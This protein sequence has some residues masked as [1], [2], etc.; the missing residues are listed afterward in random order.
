MQPDDIATEIDAARDLLAATAAAHLG[1]V[2]ADGTPR[3]VPV[4]FWWTGEEFVVSTAPE[5]PKVAALR[6]R[7]DVALSV[8]AG[9][10]PE[11]A[12]A[13]SVR[14]RVEITV[15]EGI[16]PEYLMAARRTMGE[17]SA[18]DFEAHVRTV[19][20]QQAR[21]A[22]RP[23]WARFYDYSDPD[24]MPAFLQRLVATSGS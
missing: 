14:G 9:D 20:D 16:V 17:E 21:I 24:R 2:A 1:Y 5:A 12:Q 19:F 7:P 8:E 13:L 15:V 11:S 10:T 4:G 18:A 22:I 3:T 23:T 6:E